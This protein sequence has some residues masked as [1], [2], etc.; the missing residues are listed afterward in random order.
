MPAGAGL[1]GRGDGR[2]WHRADEPTTPPLAP[3]PQLVPV[4]SRDV[5][6]SQ[7]PLYLRADEL[8]GQPSA[9]LQAQGSVELRQAGV[10][11]R[12]D[13]LRYDQAED[14]AV[15]QG[16]VRISFEGSRFSGPEVQLKVQRMEGFVREPEYHFAQTNAGGPRR[17]RGHPRPGATARDQWRLHQLPARRRAQRR[18]GS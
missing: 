6:R 10:V 3:S 15:A 5:E 11:I 1:C 8:S 16:K 2:T 12:A 14:L 13:Q 18:T 4:P 17:A 9:T 7:A